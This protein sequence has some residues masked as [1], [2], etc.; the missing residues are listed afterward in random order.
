MTRFRAATGTLTTAKS[1]VETTHQAP[2]HSAVPRAP[3]RTA[4][5]VMPASRSSTMSWTASKACLA[6][7]QAI[8]PRAGGQTGVTERAAGTMTSGSA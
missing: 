1:A 4:V 5:V 8:R 3:S 2:L 6:T 7:L